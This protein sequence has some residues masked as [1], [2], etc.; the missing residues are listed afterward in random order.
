M[1]IT[2]FVKKGYEN[3]MNE[4][5]T[6]KQTIKEYEDAFHEILEQK[7]LCQFLDENEWATTEDY[8]YVI[9]LKALKA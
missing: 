8:L 5:D 6:L 9:A 3:K 1:K 7:N 2:V 4:T